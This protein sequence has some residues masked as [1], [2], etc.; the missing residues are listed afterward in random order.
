MMAPEQI[1]DFVRRFTHQGKFTF[2][3]WPPTSMGDAFIKWVLDQY[4][5]INAYLK[6]NPGLIERIESESKA[7]TSD[8][9][10]RT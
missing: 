10:S 5:E 6:A 7:S 3:P 4:W 9:D 2:P 8:P 1:E